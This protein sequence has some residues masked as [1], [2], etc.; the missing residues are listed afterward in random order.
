MPKFKIEEKTLLMN[1]CV[2][3]VE[4]ESE[5]EA[6]NLYCEELAGSLDPISEDTRERDGNEQESIDVIN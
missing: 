6:L 4:A 3:E 5:E 1:V 2:Y